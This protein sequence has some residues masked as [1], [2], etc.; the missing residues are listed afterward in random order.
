MENNTEID[1]ILL[2]PNIPNVPTKTDGVTP[3]FKDTGIPQYQDMNIFA[4]L[5]ATRKGRTILTINE[6]ARSDPSVT[7]NFMGNN[8]NIN[9]NDPNRLN[10]T[11]NYYDGS[12]EGQGQMY[13]SFGISSIKVNISPSYVPTVN[14]TFV[15]AR[16]LS[17]FNQDDSKY[18]ILFDFPPPIFELTIKGYYGRSLKYDLHLV[19]YTTE[20]KA[21]NGNFVIDAQFI[22]MTF[23]PLTD[24]LFRYAV[25]AP[26]M[27]ENASSANPDPLSPPA[28]TFE[29]IL[30]LKSLYTALNDEA[31]N[32]VETRNYSN[33]VSQT[34][35]VNLKI[36]ALENFRE[37]FKIEPML[38]SIDN[39]STASDVP[40]DTAKRII[41]KYNTLTQFNTVITNAGTNTLAENFTTR[42]Y[43]G[44]LLT[45]IFNGTPIDNP[46]KTAL[47]GQLNSYHD[48]LIKDGVKSVKKT[49]VLNYSDISNLYVVPTTTAFTYTVLDITDYYVYLYREIGNLKGKQ[50]QLSKE[51][52]VIVNNAIEKHLGMKPTIY[53]VFKL[54]LDDVDMF[55]KTIKAT[56]QLAEPHHEKNY[57]KILTFINGADGT[58]DYKAKIFAYPLIV[59]R[60]RRIAPIELNQ[61][62]TG[63]GAPMPEMTLVTNFIYTFFR[64]KEIEKAFDPL[65][66]TNEDGTNVWIPL[67]PIDSKIANPD[68]TIPYDSQPPTNCLSWEDVVNI[69]INR[70]Y[71]MSQFAIPTNFVNSDDTGKDYRKM[72]AESEAMNIGFVM[73]KEDK[74]IDSVK[75]QAAKYNTAAAV[76]NDFYSSI[77]KVPTK[78]PNYKTPNETV[79]NNAYVNKSD[80]LYKGFKIHASVDSMGVQ[81]LLPDGQKVLEKFASDIQ[82]PLYKKI[83]INDTY[84]SLQITNQ[85][86]IYFED[87]NTVS[88]Q[89]DT[90]F[91]W[92]V[93]NAYG[94]V[95]GY[96]VK[97]LENWQEDSNAVLAGGNIA[98]NNIAN[99]VGLYGVTAEVGR[100][101]WAYVLAANDKRLYADIIGKPESSYTTDVF[102]ALILLSNFGYTM[103]P[104]N[105]RPSM[106]S[107]WCTIPSVTEVPIFLP[108]YMG[109]LVVATKT[110]GM[111]DQLLAFFQKYLPVN[112]DSANSA[113]QWN[114]SG[115]GNAGFYLL[116]DY[117]D[118]CYNLSDT[119]RSEFETDFDSYINGPG[120]SGMRKA[121]NTVVLAVKDLPTE[122]KLAKYQEFLTSGTYKTDLFGD[123]LAKTNLIIYSENTFK[124]ITNTETNTVTAAKYTPLHQ[125]FI[126][127]GAPLDASNDFFS[128]V[129]DKLGGVIAEIIKGKNDAKVAQIKAIGDVDILTQMYYSFKNINDKWLTNPNYETNGYP[130]NKKGQNLID[131]FVFVDRTMSPIGDTIINPE[132]LIDLFQ[133]TDVSIFT[134]LSRLLSENGFLFF[135][136]Q[137]FMSYTDGSWEDTFKIDQT[138]YA[139]YQQ[140]FICMYVGGSSSYPSNSSGKESGFISDG[141]DDV[142]DLKVNKAPLYDT[143]QRT[144]NPNFPWAKVRAFNV[145]FGQQNQSMF[146]DFK[147]DSKEFPETNESIQILARLAGDEKDNAPVQKAQNLYNVYE[148]R[149]YSATITGLGNAMIQPT[150]Y[151]QLD[152][153]PLYNGAYLILSVQHDITPNKMTTSFTGTKILKFPVPRVLESAVAMGE[154]IGE[155]TA[156]AQRADSESVVSA[157]GK[158][159]PKLLNRNYSKMNPAQVIYMKQQLDAPIDPTVSRYSSK[160][161]ENRLDPVDKK[162]YEKHD[163]IDL[164]ADQ[165]VPI[166]AAKAGTL[167]MKTQ[168][169]KDGSGVMTG[170]GHYILIEHDDGTET[171]YGHLV[172]FVT[173]TDGTRVNAGDIIGYC[174]HSGRGTDNHLHFGYHAPNP[175]TGVRES[176][177]PYPF[178]AESMKGTQG[179]NGKP[180]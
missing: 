56:A 116:A 135:P 114:T 110:T 113:T 168:V 108:A 129:F 112:E 144:T 40:Q 48:K 141:M 160:W 126:N 152:N 99:K 10:F 154:S 20:F 97:D 79:I 157:G 4:E 155:F 67:T 130:Y 101:I 73:S 94:I 88:A 175:K 174:G 145:K 139:D 57:D 77:S 122:Q 24:V 92:A 124:L 64:Q 169:L 82:L 93:T 140:A 166:W 51:I 105:S 172:S 136:L 119:D 61:E 132:S 74:L 3:L 107:K 29:F 46:M 117:Y 91:A 81:T 176:V 127:G 162:T 96:N 47:D 87:K 43:I 50:A 118:T 180:S 106:I 133:D 111:T 55:F 179:W 11:S 58:S 146:S 138:T 53:N 68:L 70:Y 32:S 7:V 42:L 18:R 164:A 1:V 171:L 45:N 89:E 38:F 142:N 85:N 27:P 39:D 128:Q 143:T 163:G 153:I 31:K 156:S 109:A 66:Q 35:N 37:Q 84:D 28:H 165:G 158:P 148:N 14:I 72:Y 41:T 125:I 90:K 30:K 134:V 13:E 98:L 6:G 33:N 86:I 170:Y 69:L 34:E 62:L 71:V 80:P 22:A 120:Y 178:L 16:G 151:F 150:Q 54:L 76:K 177:D 52:S 123:F 65:A 23:A 49:D 95:D 78:V 5:V 12:N 83:F 115:I 137:N 167:T 147:V 75:T 2:D 161:S 26:L 104:F 63:I 131:S 149:A 25:N 9:M 17:F 103:S 100:N 59:N 60:G 8:Q 21:E 15:D 36:K 121:L 102:S 44:Y 173:D 159:N 19:K